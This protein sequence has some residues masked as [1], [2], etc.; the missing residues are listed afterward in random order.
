[1]RTLA[2]ALVTL[3]GA[4]AF[5]GH[6][7]ATTTPG[8]VYNVPVVITDKKISVKRDQFSRHGQ[9]RLPRGALIFY[10][11]TNKGTRPYALEVWG[12]ATKV[13]KPGTRANILINW[14]Y[15][16]TYDFRL[17]FRGKPAGPKDTIVIF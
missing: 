15:R 12:A 7:S 1:M 2:V 16:G 4:A 5:A 10:K 6:G 14:N 9:L 11:V 8:V 13:M 3:A 17:L